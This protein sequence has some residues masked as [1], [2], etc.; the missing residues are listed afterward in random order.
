MVFTRLLFCVSFEKVLTT[1]YG[2]CVFV[3]SFKDT[4]FSIMKEWQKQFLLSPTDVNDLYVSTVC[5]YT[6]CIK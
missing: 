4:D 6:I 1:E 3:C 5:L 2:D